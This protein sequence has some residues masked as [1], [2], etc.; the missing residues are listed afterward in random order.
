MR[1]YGGRERDRQAL[2]IDRNSTERDTIPVEIDFKRGLEI[3]G[4]ILDEYMEQIIAG[5]NVFAVDVKDGL[6]I[7]QEIV[8]EYMLQVASTMLKCKIRIDVIA[9]VTE[10]SENTIRDLK[11]R[12][13]L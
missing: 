3:G 7:G 11:R 2:Q 12:Y 9:D 10:L 13:L 6:E 5:E 1:T 8:R 4:E